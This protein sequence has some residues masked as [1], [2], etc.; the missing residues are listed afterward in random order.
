M[1]GVSKFE[2][3]FSAMLGEYYSSAANLAPAHIE[4]REFGFGDLQRKISYRHY[5]FRTK[6]ALKSYLCENKPPFVSY[7]MAEY[8]DPIARPIENKGF[9]GAEL[10]FDLDANDLHLSC[11]PAHSSSWV[12]GNCL[13]AVK[14]ETIRLVE[15]FLIPD[16]GFS[17]DF[18]HINFSGN[19]GY[20]VHV[21]DSRV[22]PLDG[23]A[24]KEISAYIS[25]FGLDAA[26]FFPT[27]GLAGQRLIGPRPTDGGWRGKLARHAIEA[28]NRGEDA[29][30]GL[31]IEPRIARKL[32][33][34]KTEI[35]FGIGSGNWDKINI[36][37]KG[38]VWTKL[39]SG[40]AINT[41]DSIDRNVT[42]DIRHLIRLPNSI[43]GDTG[44]IAK[45]ISINGLQSFDPRKD[46]VAFQKGEMKVKTG[47][48]PQFEI[49]DMTFGPYNTG[50]TISLPT[51]AAIYIIRKGLAE[52][53]F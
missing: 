45:E 1:D 18:I 3:V 21:T 6:E 49:Q 25:G 8:K 2:A 44:L 28:L 17:A 41:G 38:E 22:F 34:N 26:N 20:H 52:P 29:L 14:D 40:L 48:V 42:N 13:S 23:N 37:K 19:R 11:A 10:V 51:S 16:F 33:K 32:V 39:L 27:L 15:D 24:R 30:V 43:H 46:A 47:A 50:Q 5:G 53:A 9:L 4:R 12:C 36:P 7:S 31:G 35:I